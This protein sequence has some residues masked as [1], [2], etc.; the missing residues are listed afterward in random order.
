MSNVIK[1]YDIP[2]QIA[3]RGWSPN[4]WKTRYT[5]NYKGL[6]FETVWVEYPDIEETCKKIGVP[7][8]GKKLD[9][10]D[11]YTVPFI[12]DPSTGAKIADSLLIAKYLD[13]TYP[14]T[15]TIIPP[16]T[17]ALQAAFSDAFM[18]KMTPLWQFALPKSTYVLNPRSEEY[19]RRTRLPLF[20]M[21]MEEMYPKGE[22]KVAEWQRLKAAFGDIDRWLG[23]EG[24]FVMGDT[25]SFSDFVIAAF[26]L[27][28]RFLFGTNS[29]EWR[30]ISSWNDRRW[31]QL[32]Q[33]LKQYEGQ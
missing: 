8:T 27:W 16:G 33:S 4:T 9:G 3:G 5:L 7:P 23:K 21:T 28:C 6:A 12:D 32:L 10:S 17:S 18:S 11:L 29:D 26:I 13:V 14:D 25:L 2:C 1:F 30:D 15:P 20:G 24:V 22:K 31:E 19:T